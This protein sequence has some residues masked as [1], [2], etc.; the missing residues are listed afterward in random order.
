MAESLKAREEGEVERVGGIYAAFAE[1][2]RQSL[3][4]LRE[5]DGAQLMLDLWPD[6]Q[7]RQRQRDMKAIEG[8]LDTLADE[9]ERELD[10]VRER[11]R[12]IRPYCT[13]A[14][15]VFAVSPQDAD[16]WKED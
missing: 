16:E 13:I 6:E 1:N 4:D 7:R 8:R 12:D 2:L 10:L 3:E 9:R 15:L 14:A 11:Y 5:E